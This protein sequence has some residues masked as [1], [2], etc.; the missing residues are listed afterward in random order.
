MPIL[1]FAGKHPIICLC[2]PGA[3]VLLFMRDTIPY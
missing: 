1:H 3:G 2:A